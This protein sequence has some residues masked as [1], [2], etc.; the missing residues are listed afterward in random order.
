MT[1]PR[2]AFATHELWPYVEGGGIGRSV[3]AAATVLSRHADVTVITS[4]D[5]EAAYRALDPDDPRAL[6]GVRMRFAREPG[7]EPSVLRTYHHRWSLALLDALRAAFPDGGPDLVEFNDYWGEGAMT[8][9]ARRGADPFLR[10]TT[11]AV[12]TR[13]THELTTALNGGELGDFERV[14][15]GLERCAL[16]GADVVLWPGGDVWGT[17]ERFYGSDA[18]APD[19]L[20]PETFLP[21]PAQPED[22]EPPPGP[23]LRLL[24]V[25][26]LER[27]KGVEELV[28][29]LL[30]ADAPDV[31]LTLVGG[32][33]DSAPDGG[34]MRA[35]LTALA[36]GDPRIEFRDRVP[37]DELAAI[38]RAHHV[39][40]SASRWESWSN[41]VREALAWNRPVLATPVGG[42]LA[43]IQPGRTG[44][45]TAG[46]GADDLRAGIEALLARR[47]EIDG[48]IAAGT[49]RAGLET[50]LDH[51][52]IVASLVELAGKRGDAT[53]AAPAA[54]AP[55]V[56]ALLT[57]E[58]GA[59][60]L[61]RS[62][63]SLRASE[64]PVRVT[65]AS[66]AGL[67]P[68]RLGTQVAALVVVEDGAP[69]TEALTA[70]LRRARG[71]E[72][73][74]IRAGQ[75]VLPGFLGRALA[76]LAADPAVAYVGAMPDGWGRAP[77]PN[78]ACAVLGED[79]GDGPVLMR[80]ADAQAVEAA[81][82][83]PDELAAI[84]SA[85]AQRG[86]WGCIIPERLV[87]YAAPTSP[88][89][90]E[91]DRVLAQLAPPAVWVAPASALPG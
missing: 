41:V 62:L 66:T 76:S 56:D 10:D 22:R 55:F 30:G 65:L 25:G 37:H 85:L 90:D 61:E 71:E 87:R 72:L 74:I 70:G 60:A 18:L 43:A 54:S 40:V 79:V 11:V 73:L 13:T 49:P 84:V 36:A 52:G 17:Y 86:R 80:R 28:R 4:N 48:L 45:L 6:P 57:W 91:D 33:T 1:K 16:R 14:L 88:P 5:A 24:Y 69:V 63:A 31:T 53:R 2:I 21:Q 75:E 82:D 3:W 27:R 47:G 12:R 44:W 23:T 58:G 38:V 39:V 83:S 77:L 34:S 7:D 29:A 81:R 8:V 51:D 9:E 64:V 59:G 68:M 20:V 32:D 19:R 67:P 35:H 42:V 78:A 46:T 50:M 89:A 15:H 26:R